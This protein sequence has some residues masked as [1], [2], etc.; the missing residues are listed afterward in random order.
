[1]IAAMDL[2]SVVV[3]LSAP[4][5]GNCEPSVAGETIEHEGVTVLGPTNLPATVSHTASQLY[6]NNITSFFEAITEDGDLEIDLADEIVDSTLLVHDG[7]V[8]NPHV[9]EAPE[10]DTGP[11][12]AKTEGDDDED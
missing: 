7:T 3:D 2:G 4:T 1:M 8:R 11:A 10:P 12:D 6:A 5:G 9:H